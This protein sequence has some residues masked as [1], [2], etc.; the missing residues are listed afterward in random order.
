MYEKYEKK[1]YLI[2]MQDRA[3][4]NQALPR[5]KISINLSKKYLKIIKF[6]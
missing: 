1:R 5:P 6:E 2:K 4:F 3:F